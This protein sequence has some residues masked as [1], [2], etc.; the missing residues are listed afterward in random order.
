MTDAL[1]AANLVVARAGA[2]TLGEFPAVGVPS[3]L[4]PYPHAG[5]HQ[6]VNAAYLA[7]RGAAVVVSDGDLAARL[8]PVVLDLLRDGKRRAEMAAAASR[9]AVP[10]AARTIAHELLR[11]GGVAEEAPWSR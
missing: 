7:D 8:A 2:G 9:L 6:A 11:L 1:L 5:A 4:V 3:V 10:D